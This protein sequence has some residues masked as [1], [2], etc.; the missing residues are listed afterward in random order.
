MVDMTS[1]TSGNM[2]QC[3]TPY[4]FDFL[5]QGN[6]M[7]RI[8]NLVVV[9]LIIPAVEL[10]Y[11]TRWNREK[12]IDVKMKTRYWN[13]KINYKRANLCFIIGENRKCEVESRLRI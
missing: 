4:Y 10:K 3:Y 9:G 11:F 6:R 5:F 8:L 7:T 12:I 1:F 13:S 2:I